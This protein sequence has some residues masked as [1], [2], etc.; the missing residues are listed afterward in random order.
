MLRCLCGAGDEIGQRIGQQDDDDGGVEGQRERAEQD[1]EVERVEAGKRVETI[2]LQP[3]QADVVIEGESGK[4]RRH[5]ARGGQTDH[6]RQEER[7]MSSTIIH[8]RVGAIKQQPLQGL[9][10]AQSLRMA[11]T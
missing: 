8:S 4:S 11:A 10:L 5:P 1:V 2:R 6:Q 7:M 9:I 3:Q